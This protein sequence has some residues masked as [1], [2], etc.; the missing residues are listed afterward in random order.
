MVTNLLNDSNNNI[1][2]MID[3]IN[4]PSKA[5]KSIA[6]ISILNSNLK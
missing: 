3:T 6:G 5:S 2:D 1:K 4:K